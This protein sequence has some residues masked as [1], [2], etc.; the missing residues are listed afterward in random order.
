[1]TWQT[2]AVASG[3]AIRYRW[4]AEQGVSLRSGL[5]RL[6]SEQLFQESLLT[7]LRD[8]PYP[9]YFFEMPPL[10]LSTARSGFEFVV[11][12]SPA[13]ADFG[14]DPR[15][16]EGP[17]ARARRDGETEVATFANLGNDALLVAPLPQDGRDGYAHLAAFVDRSNVAQWRALWRAAAGAALDRLGD[18]PLWLST[19]GL[20]VPWLHMRLDRR[21]KYYVHTPYRAG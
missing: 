15:D 11:T 2:D 1:M 14:A 5:D 19:S 16:F 8:V 13:L 12:D 20:G 17:F 10:S 3:R 18:D 21:P 6:R 4:D 7:A 9:A